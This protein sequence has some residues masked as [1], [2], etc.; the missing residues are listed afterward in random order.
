SLAALQN[1]ILVCLPCL[2]ALPHPRQRVVCPFAEVA[3]GRLETRAERLAH[4]L[5]GVALQLLAIGVPRTTRHPAVL[6]QLLL[7]VQVAGVA[8]VDMRR[9]R[10]A[11]A[12]IPAHHATQCAGAVLIVGL[13]E[14]GGFDCAPHAAARSG[15]SSQTPLPRKSAC[16]A[17][18][19][20]D[21]CGL[22]ISEVTGRYFI[23][24]SFCS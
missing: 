13:G 10:L 5:A 14:R 22:V 24:P 8:V 4:L 11:A 9:V 12:A 20:F 3:R 6:S 7:S 19:Y 18:R 1:R 23:A 16:T 17:S 15:N 2:G 21:N